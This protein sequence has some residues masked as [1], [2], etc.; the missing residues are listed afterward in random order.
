[1]NTKTIT[2]HALDNCGSGLQAYALQQF[3]INSGID[4]EIID[5]RPWYIYNNG[6]PLDWKFFVKRLLFWRKLKLRRKVYDAFIE[7]Y[8]KVTSKVYKTHSELKKANLKAD[9]FI[10]G[11]DQIW[12][13]Y[14]ECGKD[15]AYYLSFVGNQ[16]KVSYAASLGRTE[17]EPEKLEFMKKWVQAFNLVTVREGSAVSVLDS[18]GIKSERV[19]DPTFLLE[20]HQYR[21]HKIE[22]YK[23]DYILVYLTE[24]S[25]LLDKA[26]QILAAKY[27]AKIVYVGS[28]LNRCKCDV[29]LTDVGPWEFIGLID[30]ARFVIAGSFHASVFSCILNKSFAVLPYENNIRMEE[31]LNSFNLKSRFIRK[32][33]DLKILDQEIS[34]EEF[35]H[36]YEMIGKWRNDARM[37]FLE[38]L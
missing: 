11:S 22:V 8:L 19:C 5:Y 1:M 6:R 28:F 23:G 16:R 26:L 7:K 2:I 33:E 20:A 35:L 30:N 13:S 32:E 27:S 31:L 14:F 3:L 34:E 24:A 15:L 38:R 25:E 4:N 21:E 17:F 29:N 9:C 12:N 36:I 37:R 10:A 18:I